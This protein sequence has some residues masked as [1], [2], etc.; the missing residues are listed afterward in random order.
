[1]TETPS[2][3][4]FPLATPGEKLRTTPVSTTFP[5][6]LVTVTVWPTAKFC[7]VVVKVQ[8]PLPFELPPPV[9][10]A[11]AAPRLI[12]PSGARNVPDWLIVGATTFSTAPAENGAAGAA[13]FARNVTQ[14][15]EP[16][17]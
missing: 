17:V 15:A 12:V 7:P 9:S 4:G 5:S 2:A 1:M 6:E 8:V 11:A 3:G 10:D 16:S 14:L 13:P